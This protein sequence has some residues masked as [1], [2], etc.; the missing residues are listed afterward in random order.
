MRDLTGTVKGNITVINLARRDDRGNDFYGCQCTCGKYYESSGSNILRLKG[1]GC[2]ECMHKAL[3]K[4][5]LK[6]GETDTRLHTIWMHMITRCEKEKS[7]DYHLYGARGIKVCSEWHDYVTFRDWS[8]NNGYRDD[9]TLDR[10][11]VNG[12]YEPSNCRWATSIVQ[13]N[14]RR[15][16]RK[17]AIGEE[18]KTLREWATIYNVDIDLV[19]GRIKRGMNIL[20]SLT[21]PKCKA[22]EMK[23]LTHPELLTTVK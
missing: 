9:L 19:R 16:N 17:H 14:N 23:R 13:N 1:V 6:H 20:D 4:S 8:V 22:F 11:E 2:K 5:K 10:K 15:N 7:A 21:L 3:R 12:D 18:L